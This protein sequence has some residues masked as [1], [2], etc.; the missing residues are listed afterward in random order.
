MG[1]LHTSSLS[2]RPFTVDIS[3][4]TFTTKFDC[5]ESDF[6]GGDN[7]EASFKGEIEF[8]D[9]KEVNGFFSLHG[10]PWNY[11]KRSGEKMEGSSPQQLSASMVDEDLQGRKFFV[12]FQT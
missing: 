10:I 7:F 11:Q 5:K 8:R 4:S 2:V 3:L 1:I 12:G 6:E 9:G